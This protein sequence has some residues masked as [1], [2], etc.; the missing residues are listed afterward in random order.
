MKIHLPATGA[1]RTHPVYDCR[2][3]T[4]EVVIDSDLYTYIRTI[5]PEQDLQAIAFFFFKEEDAF[6]FSIL[7]GDA[8]LG[9]SIPLWRYSSFPAWAKGLRF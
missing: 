8:D 3:N 5:F 7:Y 2:G 1:G 6:V 9:Q 4:V